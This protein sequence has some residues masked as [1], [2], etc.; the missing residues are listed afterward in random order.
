MVAQ[1][2]NT[3]CFDVS[4]SFADN[5]REH[6]IPVDLGDEVVQVE[7]STM[8]IILTPD[9]LSNMMLAAMGTEGIVESSDHSEE[10]GK[11]SQDLV[12]P[13][14]LCIVGLSTGERVHYGGSARSLGWRGNTC[15]IRA[16][17]YEV[18]LEYR[19]RSAGWRET[20][21]QGGS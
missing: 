5:S 11:S 14:S 8:S 7:W 13:N 2:Y 6:N 19:L 18:S 17:H 9:I 12:G 21:N 3:G 1:L 20:R 4:R 15:T 16:R 10:P